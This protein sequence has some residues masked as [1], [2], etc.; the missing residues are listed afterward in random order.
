MAPFSADVSHPKTGYSPSV[1]PSVRPG[2][3]IVV[4]LSLTA[5][6]LL[7]DQPW[8][9]SWRLDPTTTLLSQPWVVL[10]APLTLPEG[11]LLALLTH[12][13]TQWWIGGRLEVFWGTKRYLAFA[14]ACAC[15]AI[16]GAGFLGPALGATGL[17][18]GP[19]ALDAAVLLAFAVVFGRESY[20]LPGLGAPLGARPIAVLLGLVVLMPASSAFRDWAMLLTLPG[21]LLVASTFLWQ[22]W[23]RSSKSGKLGRASKSSHLRVVRS[24]DD[25]LN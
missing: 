17:I 10:T 4:A 11:R 16:V 12:L 13:L 24:A 5:S 9:S 22:P 14:L 21:A 8:T 1:L 20:E 23:H 6:L 18:G 7:G 15:L 19:I 2:V 25:L 3:T